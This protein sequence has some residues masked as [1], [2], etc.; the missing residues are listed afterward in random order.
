MAPKHTRGLAIAT[1]VGGWF[2]RRRGRAMNFAL[3]G[4]T[5][6]GILFAP[7]MLWL[8]T[9]VGFK[10]ATQ[11]LATVAFTSDAKMLLLACVVYGF[12][13]G[14]RANAQ[15]RTEGSSRC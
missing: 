10:V 8:C 9:H 13:V 1:L 14:Y 7:V 2:E 15:R 6:A 4:A 5:A 3:S 11:S 12:S